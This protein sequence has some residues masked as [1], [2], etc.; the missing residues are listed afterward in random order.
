MA[1]Y[2]G[3]IDEQIRSAPDDSNWWVVIKRPG[4]PEMFICPLA[5]SGAETQE[6][7]EARFKDACAVYRNA[8]LTKTRQKVPVASHVDGVA[9][10]DDDF[11]RV[12]MAEEVYAMA[13]A[14]S[15]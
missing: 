4:D 8:L 11:A 2:T 14:G 3:S 6:Y 9:R 12:K 1:D 10:T 15:R 7:A 5:M 13:N